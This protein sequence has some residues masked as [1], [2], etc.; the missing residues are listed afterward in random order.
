MSKRSAIG[1]AAVAAFAVLGAQ[2]AAATTIEVTNTNDSGAGS[3]RA[4]INQANQLAGPDR[5][6]I[7]A[8]GTIPLQSQLPTVTTPMTIAGPGPSDLSLNGTALAQTDDIAVFVNPATKCLPSSRCQV[9]LRGVSIDHALKAI[10]NNGV[11]ELTNSRVSDNTFYGIV[12]SRRLTVT[13]STL[14]DNRTAIAINGTSGPTKRT[15]V[16]RSTLRGNGIGIDNG[17][18]LNVSESTLIGNRRYGIRNALRHAVIE[19]STLAGSR[20][21]NDL[22]G[23]VDIDQSTLSDNRDHP[24]ISTSDGSPTWLRSTIVANPSNG[25]ACSGTVNSQDFNLADDG[26][27][28]LTS[29]SDQPNTDPLLRPLGNYGGPTKTLALQNTS[30]AIDAGLATG[31]ATDQR[32][33]PRTVDYPGVPMAGGGDNSDVGA[34]ELQAP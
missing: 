4:A 28:H 11:L 14:S 24:V 1:I 23:S 8:T 3:L 16:R 13:D 20:V 22:S 32:G 19:T 18:T 10:Q 31:T 30:P 25:A 33:L 5:I 7:E 26:S 21:T 29:P 6:V 2:S 12:N 34:F 17:G 27:C 9:T 15:D